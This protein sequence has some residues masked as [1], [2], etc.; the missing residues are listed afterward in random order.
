MV[1]SSPLHPSLLPSRS[2]SPVPL[3]ER[4]GRRRTRSSLG[5]SSNAAMPTHKRSFSHL[6]AIATILLS[7]FSMESWTF[8]PARNKG[9]D[10]SFSQSVNFCL[11]S[12]YL[13]RRNLTEVYLVGVADSLSAHSAAEAK[14]IKAHFRMDDSGLLSLDYVSPS[15]PPPSLLS[16]LFH[17]HRWSPSLS[18]QRLRRSLHFQV[19]AQSVVDLC[20]CTT[21]VVSS[22]RDQ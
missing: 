11:L 8:C 19:S 5:L 7:P 3:W 2:P 21:D 10:T 4:M 14:G 17:K 15:P 13:G 9:N 6:I 12:S 18:T 20:V 16:H 22:H 1:S